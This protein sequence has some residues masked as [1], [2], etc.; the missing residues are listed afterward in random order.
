MEIGEARQSGVIVLT[1]HGRIDTTTAGALETRLASALT[2]ASP[3]LVVDLSGVD[4]ISS[5]GLRVL[6][7]AARR[8]QATG[9]RLALCSMGQP[10]RQVFQLAGF[11]PLFTIQDTRDQAVAGLAPP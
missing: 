2:G 3:Q 4:Y 7:V 9:G 1:P 11:L 6:L 8:V 5:A 10:V